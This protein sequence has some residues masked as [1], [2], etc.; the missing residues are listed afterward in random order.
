MVFYDN[1]SRE[2]AKLKIILLEI[3]RLKFMGFSSFSLCRVYIDAKRVSFVFIHE[4]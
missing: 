2:Q 4:S 1:K 3:K